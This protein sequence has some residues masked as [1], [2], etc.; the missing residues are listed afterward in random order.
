MNISGIPPLGLTHFT[1]IGVPPIEL[2]GLAART[3]YAS[4]GLRLYPAFP[5]APFYEIPVGSAGSREMRSRLSGE[6]ISVY[7]IEFVTIAADFVPVS[8]APMLEAAS[9]LGAQRLS[10]CGDDPDHARMVSTFAQLCDVAAD[11]GMGVDLECMAWRQVASLP[12]AAAVAQEAARPNGGVLV[13]ALHLSRTGGTPADVR[14]TSASLIRS[15]QLC[16]AAAE[17]PASTDAI[18]AE[19]RSGRLPPGHGTLPLRD[20]LRALPDGTILSVEVP[21]SGSANPEAHVRTIFSA[22]RA[23]FD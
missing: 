19:A 8:L 20:L 16:D 2:V 11:F 12:A 17:R 6:G 10:V 21:M 7:D 23:L 13:D 3:G 4:I 5:G 1:A 22:T 9:V 14:N 15:A 18:I